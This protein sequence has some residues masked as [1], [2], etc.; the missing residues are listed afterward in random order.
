MAVKPRSVTNFLRTLAD[1]LEKRDPP[2]TKFKR[3]VIT[4]EGGTVA[5]RD[6]DYRA[7]IKGKDITK[8][9]EMDFALCGIHLNI[10]EWIPCPPP[11]QAKK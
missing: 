11:T 3:I 5:G 4:A 6:F 2:I 7:I 1:Y 9:G 8:E 10:C